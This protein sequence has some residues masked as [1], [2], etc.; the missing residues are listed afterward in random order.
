M[1]II[2]IG[3][4]LINIA[5]AYNLF[6]K[7]KKEDKDLIKKEDA[8]R[9][10][11]KKNEVKDWNELEGRIHTKGFGLIKI[12]ENEYKFIKQSKLADTS[13]L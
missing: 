7:A 13:I 11:N 1:E 10:F 6:K 5:I 3:L 12:K 2:Y 9:Y 8:N 4:F